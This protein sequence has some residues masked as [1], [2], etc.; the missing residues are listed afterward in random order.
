MGL[1]EPRPTTPGSSTTLASTGIKPMLL[2]T[3]STKDDNLTIRLPQV[4]QTVMPNN[5][6]S[7]RE[8]VEIDIIKSLIASYFNVVRKNIVDAVPKSIMFFM[9]NTAKDVI[10]RECVSQLY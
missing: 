4:A 8:R 5:A 6:P 2:A 10:Q 3:E 1:E 7:D 9:V